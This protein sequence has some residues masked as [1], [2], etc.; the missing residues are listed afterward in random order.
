M[1]PFDKLKKFFESSQEPKSS[2]INDN[3]IMKSVKNEIYESKQKISNIKMNP[4]GQITGN[5]TNIGMPTSNVT[6]YNYTTAMTAPGYIPGTITTAMGG[7]PSTGYYGGINMGGVAMQAPISK[8]LIKFN[9]PTT[10]KEIV[11]VTNEGKVVWNEE[12]DIDAAAEAFSRSI[13]MGTELK[14]GITEKVKRDMRDSVFEDIIE[15]AKQKGSLN[16]EDL[17][18][19][20]QAAKIMEKLKGGK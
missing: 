3:D 8:D 11:R 20:L 4:A 12:I 15:I 19:L 6:S 14:A 18:Y 1:D 9:N 16:A 17:T 7:V 5:I 13:S 10:S 2:P